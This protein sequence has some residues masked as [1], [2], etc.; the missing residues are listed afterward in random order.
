VKTHFEYDIR[1]RRQR[2][3][4][5]A[6]ETAELERRLA[7]ARLTLERELAQPGQYQ[8]GGGYQ[9]GEG[10]IAP[11]V[12]A[13]PGGGL[14]GGNLTDD[15]TARLGGGRDRFGFADF[16]PGDLGSGADY[17]APEFSGAGPGGDGPPGS[18][19]AAGDRTEVLLHRGRS[20]AAPRLSRKRKVVIGAAA[21]AALLTILIVI[22]TAGGASWPRSVGE[23]Q[24]EAITACR[25][26]D[27]R[28]EPSQVNFACAKATRP[29]LWVFALL[30]SGGNPHFADSRSGRMGLEPIAPGQGGELAWSLNLHHPYDPSDPVDSLAVAARAINN[31][32]GGATLTGAGGKPVVQAGLESKSANCLRYTGSAA[33]TRRPGFPAH[34]ARPVTTTAGQ[35]ALVADIYQKWM[36]GAG[37]R[38]AQN[39]AVLFTNA[40]NPGDPHVQAIL[41]QLSSGGPLT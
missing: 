9:P 19:P 20:S 11:A 8:P 35:A 27:V 10:Y 5:L 34:C 23:V 40:E 21:A 29:V 26:P 36:V 14:H 32:V 30:T 13:D 12:F 24:R 39:A 31:I 7:D 25:N 18:D 33:M 28:S 22:L 37:P 6:G 15:D 41:K 38:A 17:S 4:E 1:L 16:A 3:A 2:L